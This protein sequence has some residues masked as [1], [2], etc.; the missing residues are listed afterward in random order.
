MQAELSK[1]ISFFPESIDPGKLTWL[2][3][4]FTMKWV[5]VFPIENGDF[6]CQVKLTF[7]GLKKP[8]TKKSVERFFVKE[9]PHQNLLKGV[10]LWGTKKTWVGWDVLGIILPRYVE[11]IIN[12]KDPLL[13]HLC[14]GNW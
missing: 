11:I 3:G 2:A 4:K 5:D 1:G 8:L 10:F 14:D 13:N 7:W 6:R 9:L 12:H